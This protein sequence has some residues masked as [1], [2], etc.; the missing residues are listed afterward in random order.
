[1]RRLNFALALLLIA[2]LVGRSLAGAALLN[3]GSVALLR[4]GVETASAGPVAARYLA[5]AARAGRLSALWGLGMLAH[6]QGDESRSRRL[7]RQQLARIPAPLPF[8]H[9]LYPQDESLARAA[10]RLYPDSTL[11]TFWLGEVLAGRDVDAAIALYVQALARSPQDGVRWVELGW[12]YRHNGQAQKA[13]HA[14]D[15][16]CRLRDRGGNGCWQA[17]LLAE[18]LGQ[19]AQAARYY[20]LTLR[21]IPGYTPALERL[22]GLGQ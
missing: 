7:W 17:G 12:L 22:A 21:Q 20:R 18:E 16:G 3:R 6:W 4:A 10:H 15:R 1:M 8:L 2:L 5:Q 13:L 11:A 19:S 9:I 14:Y